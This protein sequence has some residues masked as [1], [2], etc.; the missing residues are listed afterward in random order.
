MDMK[1]EEFLDT[2]SKYSREELKDYLYRYINTKR[3]LMNAVTFLDNNEMSKSK[4]GKT[5][6]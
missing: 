5:K 1:K 2:I 6:S 3:K 4:S